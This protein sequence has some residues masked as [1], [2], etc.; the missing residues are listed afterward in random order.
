M[1]IVPLVMLTH[2]HH[3]YERMD[4]ALNG[5]VLHCRILYP[6]DYDRRKPYP[7]ITFLHGIGER[8]SDNTAQLFN[9]GSLFISD[10]VRK[11]FRAIVIFPQCPADS[12]WRYFTTTPDTSSITGRH[13]D[14]PFSPGPSTPALL[15]KLLLD[16]LVASGTADPS[17]MYIMGL[18]LGGFGTLDMIERYPQ[19]F[20]A[21]VAMSGGGDV[22]TVGNTPLWLFHGRRD[23]IVDVRYSQ[24]YFRAMKKTG[25]EVR[26]TEYPLVGHNSWDYAFTDRELLPWMFSKQK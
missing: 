11:H 1:I 19:Y 24:Q 12:V 3:L 14:F 5:H 26:Y 4:F 2:D 9:G 18:S 21:A 16:S 7:V 22:Q 25:A 20:A 10:T 13:M 23:K 17:R 8:G 6:I 15:V